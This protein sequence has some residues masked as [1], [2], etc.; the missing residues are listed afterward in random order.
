M[1]RRAFISIIAVAGLAATIGAVSAREIAHAMGT[2]EVP[3]AP[4]KIVVLTNRPTHVHEVVE[5]DV[6]WPRT[7][8]SRTSPAF[9]EL[10]RHLEEVMRSMTVRPT[11]NR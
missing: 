11:V 2:T 7:P 8:A 6:E 1:L 5:V 9:I 3:D 4:Q 10:R